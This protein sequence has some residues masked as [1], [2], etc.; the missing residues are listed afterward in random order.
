[1]YYCVELLIY[2]IILFKS[3]LTGQFRGVRYRQLTG[4]SSVEIDVYEVI[5]RARCHAKYF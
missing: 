5:G 1:M 2:L 4:K 3:Y